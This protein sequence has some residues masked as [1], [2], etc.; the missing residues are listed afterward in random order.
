MNDVSADADPDTGAAVY[1]AAYGWMQVGGTSLAAPLIAGV[2]GLAA[3]ASS[4]SYSASIPYAHVASL[5]DVK[6]GNDLPGNASLACSASVQCNA[7]T[8]YDLPT[9]LGTPN[10]IGGF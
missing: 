7:A 1:D 9:G 5:H 2:Y 8:G 6:S 10:G 4:K 3:N